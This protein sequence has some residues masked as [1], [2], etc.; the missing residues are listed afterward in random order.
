M[1]LYGSN[2]L[3]SD[4]KHLF[5]NC[6]QAL[7]ISSE[8]GVRAT[9]GK[10]ISKAP[11]ENL[12]TK[13]PGEGGGGWGVGGE[14]LPTLPHGN[15]FSRRA[16]RNPRRNLADFPMGRDRTSTLSYV[17]ESKTNK[18][19]RRRPRGARTDMSEGCNWGGRRKISEDL[20]DN[21][22]STTT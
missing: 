22:P 20:Q 16:A 15:Q 8:T 9:S 2:E 13:E 11:H 18:G 6:P 4:F 12:G 19:E 1:G 14:L 7:E 10:G 3:S 5:A 21:R 17:I